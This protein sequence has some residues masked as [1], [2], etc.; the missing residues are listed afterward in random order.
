MRHK[1]VQKE[2]TRRKVTESVSRGFRKHGYAGIGIDK[3][4]KDAGVTSGAFYAHFGSKNGAFEVALNL[5]L[6]EVIEAIPRFQHESGA[7][8]VQ[9]FVDYYL[10]QPHIKDL[11]CGCAMASLTP[12]VVRSD[13]EF[14]A[15]YETK[16]VRI[17][18]LIA[19][20]LLEA[21]DTQNARGRAWAL[22]SLLT[23]GLNMV[24]AMN[25]P[26]AADELIEALKPTALAVAGPAR[27]VTKQR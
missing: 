6:D 10:G 11:E 19:Q 27:A 5:G 9:A 17:A 25:S 15:I 4:A 26:E 3:L 21:T 2:E 14:H 16:M 23:G 8:W 12:E 22:L 7:A 20:G 1:G 13:A 24:R 18:G